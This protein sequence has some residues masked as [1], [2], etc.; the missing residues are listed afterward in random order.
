M[1]G[2]FCSLD[3]HTTKTHQMKTIFYPFEGGIEEIELET[4]E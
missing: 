1:L 3:K 2:I 4:E